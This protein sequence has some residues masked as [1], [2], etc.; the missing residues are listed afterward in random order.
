LKEI[1]PGQGFWVDSKGEFQLYFQGDPPVDKFPELH[2]GWNLVGL[3]GSNNMPVSE[4]LLGFDLPVDSIWKWSQDK[5]TW[6][7]ILPQLEDN[8]T[9]Y[10]SGKGFEILEV[11]EPGQGFWINCK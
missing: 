5:D 9:T 11:L 3:T 10:A 7:V 8:G 6:K 4:V 2:S 1:M